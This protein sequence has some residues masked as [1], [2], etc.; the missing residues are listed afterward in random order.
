MKTQLRDDHE[1]IIMALNTE[2]DLD[3]LEQYAIPVLKEL[4]GNYL[5][6]EEKAYLVDV[7]YRAL[8]LAEATNQ[9]S[10]LILSPLSNGKRTA[11]VVS[12]DL[13]LTGDWVNVGSIQPDTDSWTFDIDENQYYIIKESL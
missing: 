1:Y 3:L 12:Q 9:E 13:L 5:G 8:I 2:N 7:S 11:R 10:I 4:I 6:I